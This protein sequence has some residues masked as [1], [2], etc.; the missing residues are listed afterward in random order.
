MRNPSNSVRKKLLQ[1]TKLILKKCLDISR[2]AET[3][4]AQLKTMAGK[5]AAEADVHYVLK[6][7]KPKPKPKAKGQ[8]SSDVNCKYCGQ[9]LEKA[10]KKCPAFGRNAA[11]A[12]SLI[13]SQ[14]MYFSSNSA[15]GCNAIQ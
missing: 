8:K 15:Y 3:T 2:A 1:E 11:N 13:T 12:L 14:R 4:S 6:H 10:K 7:G 9:T 5:A